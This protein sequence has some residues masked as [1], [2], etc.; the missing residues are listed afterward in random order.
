MEEFERFKKEKREKEEFETEQALECFEQDFDNDIYIVFHDD[1]NGNIFAFPDNT[2]PL[3]ILAVQSVFNPVLTAYNFNGIISTI[4]KSIGNFDRDN[5]SAPPKRTGNIFPLFG[6]RK[7]TGNRVSIPL[8]SDVAT[9]PFI[10]PVPLTSDLEP[11]R[12][13]YFSNPYSNR[14]IL[15]FYGK[16]I[17]VFLLFTN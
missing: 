8:F 10:G 13:D 12:S 6:P 2:D 1:D 17:Y 7:S 14:E 3:D 11:D 9:N 15:C 4:L 5:P 16:F